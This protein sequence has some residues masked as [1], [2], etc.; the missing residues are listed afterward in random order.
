MKPFLIFY[1]FC[2][3]Y[4]L[5][6]CQIEYL[7]K[8]PEIIYIHD[9]VTKSEVNKIK[10]LARGHMHTTPYLKNDPNDKKKHPEGIH[11]RFSQIKGF[12]FNIIHFHSHTFFLPSRIESI[13]LVDIQ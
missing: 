12:T 6:T 2:S 11:Y 10:S 4:F 7:H 5:L 8:F 13:N 3:L 1:S 9:L